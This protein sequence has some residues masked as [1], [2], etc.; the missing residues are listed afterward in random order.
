M[1]EIPRSCVGLHPLHSPRAHEPV[2]LTDAAR[3]GEDECP[4]ELRGRVGEHVG[5]VGDDHTAR[6]RGGNVDVVVAH[7][8]VRDD[9]E[10]GRSVEE[11]GVDPLGQEAQQRAVCPAGPR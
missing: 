8:K 1:S 11:L 10:I 2:A 4:R 6:G 3:R 7:G 5:S 9:P